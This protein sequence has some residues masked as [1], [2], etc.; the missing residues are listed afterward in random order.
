IKAAIDILFSLRVELLK[1]K[2]HLTEETLYQFKEKVDQYQV[3]ITK[4]Y[5][6][7][8][9]IP[10]YHTSHLKQKVEIQ[11]AS[12]QKELELLYNQLQAIEQKIKILES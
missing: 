10:Q 11:L 2:S 4:Y 1:F 12:I 3:L 9:A 7:L 8:T 6:L 5:S